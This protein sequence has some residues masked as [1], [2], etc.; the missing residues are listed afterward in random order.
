[1]NDCGIVPVVDGMLSRRGWEVAYLAL[2][3]LMYCDIALRQSAR[4]LT[5][6]WP[7]DGGPVPG[8]ES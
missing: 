5:P 3:P 8:R 1:M 2:H 7:R 4:D 6:P